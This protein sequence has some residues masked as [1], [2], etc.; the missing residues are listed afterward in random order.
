M[1]LGKFLLEVFGF[2]TL[3][4]FTTLLSVSPT[5][6]DGSLKVQDFLFFYIVIAFFVQEVIQLYKEKSSYLDDPWNR[7]DMVVYAS[8][9]AT[10]G[11]RIYYSVGDTQTE[12]IVVNGQLVYA[13]LLCIVAVTVWI[14]S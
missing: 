2:T 7:V 10:M 3:V 14:R 11:L 4:V 8:S 9:I 5:V 12:G 13:V 6:I 1:P